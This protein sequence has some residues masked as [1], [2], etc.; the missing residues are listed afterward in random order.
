MFARTHKLAVVEVV[1]VVVA[2]LDQRSRAGCSSS[3][4]AASAFT[5][6]GKRL[7]QLIAASIALDRAKI[8]TLAWRNTSIFLFA[9]LYKL[10]PVPLKTPCPA[11][12]SRPTAGLRLVLSSNTGFIADTARKVCRSGGDDDLQRKR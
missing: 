11:L 12:S 5:F 6:I 8:P 9:V 2:V 7:L 4:T 10:P 3:D 1:V